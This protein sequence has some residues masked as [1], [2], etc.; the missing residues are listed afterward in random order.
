MNSHAEAV[1]HGRLSKIAQEKE[2]VEQQKISEAKSHQESA[3]ANGISTIIAPLELPSSDEILDPKSKGQIIADDLRRTIRRAIRYSL[4]SCK[5]RYAARR[6]RIIG[7]FKLP[8]LQ[9]Y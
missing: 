8:C 7:K 2:R 3:M 1:L 6:S 5:G 4:T 9:T